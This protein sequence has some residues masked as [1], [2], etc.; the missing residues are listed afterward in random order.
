LLEQRAIA[1]FLDRETLRID[2]LV[3][4][5]RDAIAHLKE[6]RTAVISAAV[7]GEIDV[8]E[9]DNPPEGGMDDQPAPP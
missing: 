3:A 5:V 2:T 8:R 9:A 7:T 4:K 1:A 6:L